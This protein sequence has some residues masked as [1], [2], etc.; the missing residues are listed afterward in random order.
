MKF[1]ENVKLDEYEQF[2]QNNPYKSHFMQSSA[3][4]EVMKKKNFTPHFLGMKKGDDL[5]I[6]ALLLEKKLIG[7]F[8]YFYCPRG[9]VW[10]YNDFDILNTFSKEL[11]KYAKK[12]RAIFIKIDPDIK[13]H[14]LDLDGNIID[15]NNNYKLIEKLKELGYKNKG[16]NKNFVNEQ[17]RFTFRLNLC[18]DFEN[19]KKNMHPTT[20][21]IYNKGN[22]YNLN[23]YIGNESDIDSFYETML[24]TAKRENIKPSEIEYYKHFYKILNENKMSDLYVVKV[25]I[26][27]LKQIYKNKIEN[28]NEQINSIDETKYKNKQKLNNKITEYKNEL[29]KAQKELNLLNNIEKEEITLSS[30]MT[31]KYGNKVWTVHGGNH[32]ILRELNSNYLLYFTIIK[33]AYDMGYKMI[34]FFGTSGEANPDKD[35]PIYGIHLFKKRLGGEYTEFIGEYDLIIN[36]FLYFSYKKLIPIYR[37][38]KK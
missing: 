38:I 13:R 6:T 12:H 3:W 2:V 17:P 1:I 20:R 8:S 25:N 15:D 10:D 18:D 28:I 9:F 4:G 11:R 24:E 14:N 23:L 7:K 16:F 19:I 32:S 21:K 30:I 29:L 27:N 5:V 36:K 22:Q 26:N 31:V 37:K 35:N 33:D 34:D